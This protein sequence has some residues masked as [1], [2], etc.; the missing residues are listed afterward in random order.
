M[1]ACKGWILHSMRPK[2]FFSNQWVQHMKVHILSK[3]IEFL[4]AAWQPV[5]GRPC[6]AG[7]CAHQQHICTGAWCALG[8]QW[9]KH[10]QGAGR[11]PG[12]LRWGEWTKDELDKQKN[13][14][15]HIMWSQ[16]W[17]T[18]AYAVRPSSVGPGCWRWWWDGWYW[19][20]GAGEQMGA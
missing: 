11:G 2:V 6:V 7:G 1:V 3:S 15:K 18:Y 17:N 20:S 14:T 19:R 16:C 4:P 8:R 10:Q 12:S 9:L 13:K 5:A